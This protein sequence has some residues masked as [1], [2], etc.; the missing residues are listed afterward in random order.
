MN[1]SEAD[2]VLDVWRELMADPADRCKYGNAVQ[3]LF[4]A[5]LHLDAEVKRLEAISR[6]DVVHLAELGK[7]NRDLREMVRQENAP[8][9]VEPDPVATIVRPIGWLRS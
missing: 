7:A 5:A 1:R 3:Q 6:L 9:H 2:A 4:Y 8:E